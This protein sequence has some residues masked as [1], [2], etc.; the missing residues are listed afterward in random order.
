M[1]KICLIIVGLIFVI[2]DV[3]AVDYTS[4]Y[5]KANSKFEQKDYKGAMVLFKQAFTQGDSINSPL[6]IGEMYISGLGTDADEQ[7]AL[8]W[9]TIA[10]DHDNA[11]AQSIMGRYYLHLNDYETAVKWFS[12]AADNGDNSGKAN[13]AMAY[14]HGKG[15]LLRNPQKALRLMLAAAQGNYPAAQW[16]IAKA[17]FDGHTGRFDIDCDS[18]Q[19]VY[20]TKKAAENGVAEAQYYLGTIYLEGFNNTPVDKKIAKEWLQKSAAQDYEE[21]ITTLKEQ[22]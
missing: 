17:Y 22:F 8:R 5:S 15:G 14:L 3:L 2:P 19:F 18:D 21:A 10:A 6:R 12:K 20:W 7:E 9:V 11:I 1:R 16:E 13:L 4:A